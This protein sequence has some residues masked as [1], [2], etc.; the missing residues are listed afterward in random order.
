MLSQPQ[1]SG[2]QGGIK[3]P[4]W[5]LRWKWVGAGSDSRLDQPSVEFQPA[6]VDQH[7]QVPTQVQV[8]HVAVSGSELLPASHVDVDAG[9]MLKPVRR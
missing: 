7:Y 5:F 6:R 8:E 4:S 2:R 9:R 3:V 1:S